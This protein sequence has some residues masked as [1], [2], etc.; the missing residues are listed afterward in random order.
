MTHDLD[1]MAEILDETG[2]QWVDNR[3]IFSDE[4]RTLTL[5]VERT[6]YRTDGRLPVHP[7]AIGHRRIADSVPDSWLTAKP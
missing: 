7:S 2:A 6:W 3:R 1:L 4:S 5:A